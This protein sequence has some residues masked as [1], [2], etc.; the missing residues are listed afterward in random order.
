MTGYTLLP[1]TEADAHEL[2]PLLRA[3]DRDEVLALGAEPAAALLDSVRN[4]REALTARTLDGR[5]ICM[6]GVNPA[7]LIGRVGI[8]WLMGSDL[9]PAYRRAFMVETR[10][11]VGRWQE[12]FPILRNVV[13]AR[14]DEAIRWLRWLRFEIGEPVPFAHGLFRPFHREA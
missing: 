8:P 13:D 5:I 4:A 3:E 9:V 10:R 7:T 2:A 14:Y 12:T 11:M 1:A 6:A